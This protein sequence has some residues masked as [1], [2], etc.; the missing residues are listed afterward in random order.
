MKAVQPTATKGPSMSIV[1]KQAR[2]GDLAALTA[3][4]DGYRQFYAQR[5]DPDLARTFLS[6]RFEHGESILFLAEDGA[7]RAVGII[8]LYPS[9]SST[10]A[11]R[12]LILNDLFVTPQAR[13]QGA[14]R[15]LLEAAA[16]YGRGVGA[17]ELTLSTART[18]RA[19]Q[20]LYEKAGWERDEVYLPYQL[21][22]T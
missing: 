18:N 12:I 17:V 19:A 14:G 5:S 10:R 16:A 8:Q 7:G 15:R 1:V 3:L 13:G 4:F 2:I 22:L 20:A 21:A 6:D 11:A 9:F